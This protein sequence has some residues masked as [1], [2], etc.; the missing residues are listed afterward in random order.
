MRPLLAMIL[1]A[2][3]GGSGP[4]DVVCTEGTRVAE[5]VGS[6]HDEAYD[7]IPEAKAQVC[8]RQAGGGTL[9]CLPPSTTASDGTFAIGVPSPAQCM[10]RAVMRVVLPEASYATAYC[11][12]DLPLDDPISFTLHRVDPA[13]AL[14]PR[15]DPEVARTVRFADGL[16]LDMTPAELSPSSGYESLAARRFDP[17]APGICFLDDPSHVRALYAF[18]PETTVRAAGAS[19]RIPNA[20]GL[21]PGAEVPLFVLGGLGCERAD[22]TLI[23]EGEWEQFG[24]GTVSEDGAFIVGAGLP[25]LTWMGH[26]APL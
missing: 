3:C 24:T 22:G 14:P 26:G 8:S 25:C 6:V 9:L 4:S 18:A 16:E 17:R 20:D 19:V 5:V 1:C 11:I 15:G 7:P 23:D 13:N 10:E 12:Q 21:S 2:S